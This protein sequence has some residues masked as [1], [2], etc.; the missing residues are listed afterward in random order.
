MLFKNAGIH[1]LRVEAGC[2]AVDFFEGEMMEA[3]G[4]TEIVPE[5]GGEKWGLK[6]LQKAVGGYIEIV[7]LE[8]GILMVVD[9][10]GL[11]KDGAR[12]NMVA[13]VLSGRRIVGDVCL[14]S[15]ADFD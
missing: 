4:V 9:E 13:S 14:I 5:K 1:G 7:K 11:L 15:E 6:E 8:T 10:E 12:Q 3:V 2:N